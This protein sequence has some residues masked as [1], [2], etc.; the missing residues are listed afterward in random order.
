MTQQNPEYPVRLEIDHQERFTRLLPLVKWLLAIPHYVAL[1]ILGIAALVALV[2]SWF[3][4]L[5]TGRYPR[6][7]FNFLVGFERWRIR[8][9]AYLLRALVRAARA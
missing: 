6:A 3:A 2:I 8:V 9:G 5:I 1:W 7:M 4:V